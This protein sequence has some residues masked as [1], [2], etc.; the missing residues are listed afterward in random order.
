MNPDSRFEPGKLYESPNMHMTDSASDTVIQPRSIM[1]YVGPT[2]GS[3][4]LGPSHEAT[5]LI[6]EKSI[7]FSQLW[8]LKIIKAY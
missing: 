3:H 8:W 1:M 4:R 5:F 2:P 6:K 7:T